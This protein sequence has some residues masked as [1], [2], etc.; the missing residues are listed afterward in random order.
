[1]PVKWCAD[2]SSSALRELIGRLRSFNINILRASLQW[3]L[4]TKTAVFG[5]TR[6][7]RSVG[8]STT[9]TVHRRRRRKCRG[10]NA[11]ATPRF[12]VAAMLTRAGR[13]RSHEPISGVCVDYYC[14]CRNGRSAD[15]VAGYPRCRP[16]PRCR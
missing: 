5:A 4:L 16:A 1:M 8:N 3:Y 14:C 12:S 2:D 6:A 13:A 11:V 10:S 9:A 15:K 7:D